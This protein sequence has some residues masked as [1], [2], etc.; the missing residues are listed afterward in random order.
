MIP[1]VSDALTWLES[2]CHVLKGINRGIERETLRIT[3]EGQ[4]SVTPFP[5]S[6]GAALTHRWITTDFAE[7][8]LEFITPV[9]QNID[10]TLSFLS[11]LHRYSMNEIGD[12]LMWPLS[13]PCYLAKED[14]IVLAQYGTSNVGKM[15]TLYRKGLKTRYGAMMQTISGVHYNFSLPLQF[16]QE[17]LGI[18]DAESGKA[19]ISEGY[20]KLIRNYYRFGWV[21]PYLFG[22]SPSMCSSFI[23]DKNKRDAFRQLTNG[24][25]FLPHATSLRM[26]DLG[27]TNDAQKQ[28]KI[29]FNDLDT[30]VDGIRRATQLRSEAFAELG[31]KVDGE[32]R[33]LNDHVLQIENEFYVPI[34]PKSV[35]QGNERPTDALLNR[36][37]QYI[38]VRALDINPFTPI[39]ITEEQIRFL[40][41]FLVWCALADAPEMS[42]DELNCA[43][44]NWGRVIMEGRKPGLEIGL[45]CGI[46]REPLADV[47]KALFADLLR[48]ADVIDCSN[49]DKAYRQVAEKLVDCFDAPELTLSGR[50]L[51][52]IEDMG[53]TNFGLALAKQYKQTLL[54]E[55]LELLTDEMLSQ[56]QARSVQAQAEIEAG[57]TLSFDD[58]LAKYVNFKS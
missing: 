7:S 31:V 19:A 25:Y 9:N 34:R 27:Y 39:G 42:A 17:R 37:V 11:D 46:E 8:M 28:L 41:L 29:T 53:T 48:V 54:Q 23:R 44:Q 43:Q 35:P 4:L 57:D 24:N 3:P 47:G 6:I 36:G 33:Q 38:E 20:F 30:Y 52:A 40:D 2:H 16:W 21:I 32:Y 58:Y 26:S 49:G 56:E 10:E 45:G 18:T 1:N 12:E 13:M 14:D 51:Q 55:P 15:K 22:A 50:M 5:H